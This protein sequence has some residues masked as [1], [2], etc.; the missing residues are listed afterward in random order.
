MSKCYQDGEWLKYSNDD[1]G[2]YFNK[3][4]NDYRLGVDEFYSNIL[5]LD[6]LKELSNFLVSYIKEQESSIK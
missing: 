6:E 3:E 4:E 1:L 5:N 2:L